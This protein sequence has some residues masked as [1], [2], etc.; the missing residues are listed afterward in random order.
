MGGEREIALVLVIAACAAGALVTPRLRWS[1]GLGT[2]LLLAAAVRILV[3]VLAE[4]IT[5]HDVAVHFHAIARQVLVGHDPALTTPGHEWNFLPLMPYLWAALLKTGLAWT[6][7]MKVVPIASDLVNVWLVGILCPVASR[8]PVVRVAYA[9]NPV[10][11]LVVAVHGQV[12]PTALMFLLGGLVLVQRSADFA[13]GLLFGL[14]I[15]TK[16]W[17]VLV[18]LPVL[19]GIPGRA[20]R[21][22]TMTLVVLAA[23]ALS[24]IV[25]LHSGSGALLKKLASYSSFTGYWGWAGT[26]V[27]FGH[28]RFMGYA[29]P[30]DRWGT[31][32]VVA[33][34]IAT[35]VLF[36]RASLLRRAWTTPMASLAVASGFGPQY[37]MWPVPF[38]TANEER[39]AAYLLSA[40]A[41]GLVSYLPIFH[42]V[43]ARQHV[44]TAMS[45]LV[46][47]TMAQMLWRASRDT[48]HP[49]PRHRIG[50]GGDP[51]RPEAEPVASAS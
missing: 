36:R 31:L 29:S 33:A 19:A 51:R 45:W 26:I 46:I 27:A 16:T 47:A 49:T 20:W 32:L 34:V 24:S 9:L 39:Q 13:A 50:A 11:V 1:P 48:R 7:I 43:S 6:T 14:A 41:Y 42:D 28:K 5:P 38:L 17:P 3:A 22:A 35:L 8:R 21:A 44:L 18:V 10:V 40:T 23:F 37:L 15:A 30:V 4:P 2:A 25:I 12:E